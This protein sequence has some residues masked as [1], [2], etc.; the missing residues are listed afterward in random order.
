[1][2]L[3]ADKKPEPQTKSKKNNSQSKKPT[4]NATTP[5]PVDD[6]RTVY[7]A[8]KD[9]ISSFYNP[10]K[11]TKE[12]IKKTQT[13]SLSQVRGRTYQKNGLN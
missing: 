10:K 11:W 8:F 5:P 2:A 7:R 9:Y 12:G 1:M 13:I 3:N 6:G 4:T